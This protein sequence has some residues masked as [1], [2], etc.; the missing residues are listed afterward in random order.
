[1]GN[2][3]RDIQWD[4]GLPSGK[5]GIDNRRIHLEDRGACYEAMQTLEEAWEEY[6]PAL[7][8]SEVA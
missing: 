7:A 5:A 4:S 6:A 1:V 3:A 2:L 8:D